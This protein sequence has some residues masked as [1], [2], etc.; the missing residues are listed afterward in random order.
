MIRY[1]KKHKR[2]YSGIFLKPIGL[3]IEHDISNTFSL[4]F[5]NPITAKKLFKVFKILSTNPNDILIDKGKVDIIGQNIYSYKVDYKSRLIY[6]EYNGEKTF[7]D[8]IVVKRR[9]SRLLSKEKLYN[10]IIRVM[11]IIIGIIGSLLTSVLLPF[12]SLAI[13]IEDRGPIFDKNICMDKNG[14]KYLR[15]KFRTRYTK[16]C[17]K[18]NELMVTIM[19][20]L[21]VGGSV[22]EQN[23]PKYDLMREVIQ[24]MIMELLSTTKVGGFLRDTY[25]DILPY[26]FHLLKGNISIQEIIKIIKLNQIEKKYGIN[27]LSEND[28][29]KEVI[30]QL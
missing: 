24:D 10:I 28:T 8:Y 1:N 21:Y 17:S 22:I 18:K 2:L 13:I 26:F 30:P 11:G 29:D 23:N 27:M 4:M 15:Y 5:V 16:P 14:K 7:L 25:L 9:P 12:I 20:G 6:G 19:R 3:N